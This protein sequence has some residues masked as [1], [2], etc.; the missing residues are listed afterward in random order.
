MEYNSRMSLARA[1]SYNGNIN[2]GNNGI[3]NGVGNQRN[4][5]QDESDAFMT[6]VCIDMSDVNSLDNYYHHNVKIP[7]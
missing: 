4:R 6:L 1:S 7:R 3:N 2:G 5:Q